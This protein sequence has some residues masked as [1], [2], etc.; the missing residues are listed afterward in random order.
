MQ[1]KR[2]IRKGDFVLVTTGK[3]K[4][5]SGE[6]TKVD[7]KENRLIVKGVNLVTKHQKKTKT[8]QGEKVLKELPIHISNV[9]FYDQ[10]LKIAT[11]IGFTLSEDGI[12]VRIGKKTK[13]IIPE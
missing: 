1:Y 12:K 6:V 10:D 11:K 7:P 8:S 2:K 3:D 13:K 5:K 9:A 4:G